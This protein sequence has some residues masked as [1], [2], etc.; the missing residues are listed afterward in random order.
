[1]KKNQ[2]ATT[3]SASPLRYD[4]INNMI[5]GG[6]EIGGI[7]HTTAKRSARKK[8]KSQEARN[9][10]HLMLGINNLEREHSF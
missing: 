5:Y 9:P 3:T 4:R 8:N 1:M 6:S 2:L 7:M 10:K